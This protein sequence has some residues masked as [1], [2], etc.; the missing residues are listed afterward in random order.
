LIA[1]LRSPAL[2]GA[3]SMASLRSA[4]LNGGDLTTT[5]TVSVVSEVF[6]PVGIF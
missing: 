5:G 6:S 4:A 1:L 2:I 3:E